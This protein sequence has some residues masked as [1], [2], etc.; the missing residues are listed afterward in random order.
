MRQYL[1]LMSHVLEH[2]SEKKD[3]TG[4]GT[5]SVFGS[6]FACT[7]ILLINCWTMPRGKSL[8]CTG[9]IILSRVPPT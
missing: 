7:G 5:L 9:R 8:I 4:T 2:G 3:R 1:E 6:V